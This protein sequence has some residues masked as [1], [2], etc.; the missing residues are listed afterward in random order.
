MQIKLSDLRGLAPL[1]LL[2]GRN[3]TKADLL[4]YRLGGREV[5]LKDYSPRPWWIRNTLGRFLIRRESAAYRMATGLAG[6]PRF[7]GRVGSFAL[8]VDWIQGAPL[9]AFRGR[10]VEAARFDEL[11][12]IVVGLH[13]RGIALGDL[14]HRDVLIADAGGVFVVDLATAWWLGPQPRRWRRSIFERLKEA[15]VLALHHMRARYADAPA[16]EGDSSTPAWLRR[17]RCAKQLWNRLRGRLH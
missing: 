10:R 4:V 8:A 9:S 2:P 14:H 11:H 16:D 15:D 1:R 12:A 17:A 6:L 3:W 13:G 7:L 5:A